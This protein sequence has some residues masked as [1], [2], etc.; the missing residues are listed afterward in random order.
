MGTVLSLSIT[1]GAALTGGG[2]TALG[3]IAGATGAFIGSFTDFAGVGVAGAAAATGGCTVTYK[4][5]RVLY[6]I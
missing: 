2:A 1:I 4:T 6:Y 3:F 5:F